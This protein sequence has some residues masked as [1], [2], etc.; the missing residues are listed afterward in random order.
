ML[1]L[2]TLPGIHPHSSNYA[3][4]AGIP[5]GARLMVSNGHIG[6]RLDGS[7]PDGVEAQTEVILERLQ[8]VLEA[9]GMT[10]TDIA[11][12]T[13]FLTEVEYQEAY[14]RARDRI[15]GD[16]KPP[17]PIVIVKALVRLPLKVEIEIIAAKVD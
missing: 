2:H 6:T 15:L 4:G 8:A 5:A 16:H 9:D 3:H 1:T 14:K 13:T 12:L 7:T 10:L 11:R 17:N